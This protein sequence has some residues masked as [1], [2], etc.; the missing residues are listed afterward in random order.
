MRKLVDDE[1]LR[2]PSRNVPPK[3]RAFSIDGTVEGILTVY[4][5]TVA[6][7]SGSVNST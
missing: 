3:E 2:R 1:S 4:E 6:R 5:Q 7:Y